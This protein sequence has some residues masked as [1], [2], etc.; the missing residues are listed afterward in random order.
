LW[1]LEPLLQRAS[2][3]R[4]YGCNSVG[5]ASPTAS[6]WELTLDAARYTVV[7][8]PEVSRGFSGEGGLLFELASAD[9]Q[10]DAERVSIHLGWGRPLDIDRLAATTG[11]P[12][13]RTRSALMFLAAQGRVGFDLAEGTYFHRELPFRA[14]AMLKMNPRLL[15]AR[16]LVEQG[17]VQLESGGA[18]V[19]SG[20]LEH[21]VT[22]ATDHD[23][24]TCPWWGKYSGTRGPCKHVLAAQIASARPQQV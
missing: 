9:A 6:A 18:R 2:R 3:L 19:L 24:C 20:D 5:A 14:E 21:R 1:S 22:F 7:L 17:N 23:R 15:E 10:L 11:L 4:V 8:S 16:Q 13:D 12:H